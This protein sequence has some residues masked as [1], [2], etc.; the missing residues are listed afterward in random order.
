M[1]LGRHAVFWAVAVFLVSTAPANAQA[2]SAYDQ[3]T[4]NRWALNCQGCHRPNGG[5]TPGGAPPMRGVV[6]SFLRVE[7]GRAY[8]TQVPG[9]AT[10]PLRDE[11]LAQLLNYVLRR[12]DGAGLP[13]D[14]KPYTAAEVAAGRRTLLRTDA[15][16]IRRRLMARL[17]GANQQTK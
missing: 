15:A 11:E 16:A 14:F 8:L 5:G 7:G 3:A 1:S 17:S 13:D 9:V 4:W 12:F 10:A 6:G 2:P